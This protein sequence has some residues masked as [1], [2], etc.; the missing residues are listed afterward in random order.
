MSKLQLNDGNISFM[1]SENGGSY[2]SNVTDNNWYASP[3][4]DAVAIFSRLIVKDENVP[5]DLIPFELQRESSDKIV[6]KVVAFE[7]PIII[8]SSFSII[9]AVVIPTVAFIYCCCR[10]FGKCGGSRSEQHVATLS[11]KNAV[12]IGLSLFIFTLMTL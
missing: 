10:L 2:E 4:S 8:L 11:D 9:L 3:L 12:M 7:Q 5:L 1:F 6:E